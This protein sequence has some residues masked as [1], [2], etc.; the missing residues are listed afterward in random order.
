MSGDLKSAWYNGSDV[1]TVVSPYSG[2]YWGLATNNES[3]FYSNHYSLLKM[4]KGLWQNTTVVY[5]DTELIY[6]I[7]LYKQEGENIYMREKMSIK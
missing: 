6:G 3:F 4:R 5:R 7:L 1:K 2:S